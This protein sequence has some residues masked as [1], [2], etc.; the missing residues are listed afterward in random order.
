MLD[1]G[2]LRARRIQT[3]FHGECRKAAVM[4]MPI[5]PLFGDGK[6]NFPIFDDGRRRVGM[7]H[8][9]AQN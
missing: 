9:Q 8:I 1:V 4:F 2:D 5:Q 6:K 7:K 3:R